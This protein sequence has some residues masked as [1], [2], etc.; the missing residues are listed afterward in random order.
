MLQA[1]GHADTNHSTKVSLILWNTQVKSKRVAAV[2][3]SFSRV[4]FIGE[5]HARPERV[6][7]ESRL[8][9]RRVL[10]PIATWVRV[11]F[12]CPL[13]AMGR[14]TSPDGAP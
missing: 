4:L 14:S 6:K 2:T 5:Y 11:R 7:T 13:P 1:V 9:D 8:V 3:R 10:V 12:G